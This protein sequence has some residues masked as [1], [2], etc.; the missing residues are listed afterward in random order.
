MNN[1]V[2]FAKEVFLNDLEIMKEVLSLA[3]FKL[4]K[5]SADYEYFKRQTMNFFYNN[6]IRL[7]QKLESNSILIKCECAAKLR[8][9]FSPCEKCGGSGYKNKE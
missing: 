6:L 4:G 3:E 8:H 2:Q 5:D 9:G 7:F 1:E